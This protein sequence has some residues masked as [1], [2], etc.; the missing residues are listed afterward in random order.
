M[1]HNRVTKLTAE[2]QPEL[3]AEE[4]AYYDARTHQGLSDIEAGRVFSVDEAKRRMTDRIATARAATRR[5]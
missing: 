5:A 4:A 3:T 1:E 2:T